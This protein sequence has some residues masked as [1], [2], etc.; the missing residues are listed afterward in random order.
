MFRNL[1]HWL[2][3]KSCKLYQQGRQ[4]IAWRRRRWFIASR[5]FTDRL[6]FLGRSRPRK[7]EPV[8]RTWAKCQTFVEWCRQFLWPRSL[9]SRSQRFLVRFLH[10]TLEN[11]NSVIVTIDDFS[12]IKNSE[13]KIVVPMGQLMLVDKN[14]YLKHNEWAVY[15]S[16][17]IRHTY[18]VKVKIV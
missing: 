12:T 1:L 6:S 13:P 14:R 18:L 9:C 5:F 11:G 4:Q 17:Q 2:L 10:L 15:Y 16:T 3:D 7:G 8:R